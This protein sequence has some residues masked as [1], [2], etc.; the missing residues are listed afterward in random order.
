M[1]E[2]EVLEAGATGFQEPEQGGWQPVPT[3]WQKTQSS[4]IRPVN[5]SITH[6]FGGIEAKLDV[7]K[8]GE[9]TPHDFIARR[10]IISAGKITTKS[11][12]LGDVERQRPLYRAIDSAIR[13]KMIN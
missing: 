3:T 5:L 8:S 10:R 9:P 12:Q 11:G 13:N 7:G 4:G 1:S 2:E 6:K